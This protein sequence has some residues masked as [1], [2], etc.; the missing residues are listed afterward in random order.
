VFQLLKNRGVLFLSLSN[1]LAQLDSRLIHMVIITLVGAMFPG[2][3]SAF[4]GFAVAYSLPVIILAPFV[5]VLVDHWNRKSIMVRSHLI[6]TV[7]ICLTPF[8]IRLTHSFIP[9]WVMVVLFFSLEVFYNTAR[10]TS[11]PDLVAPADLIPANAIITAVARIATFLGMVAGAFLIKATGWN[12]GF[13]I[14][15]LVVLAA[16]LLILGMG[17][18]AVFEP[19]IKINFSLSHKLKKS[20]RVF[21]DDLKE[22]GRLLVHDRLVIFVMISVCVLPFVSAIAYTVLVYLIQQQ[23]RLGT[24]GVGIFG[25]VIGLGMLAGA[26]L[27]GFL[28]RK[29]SRGWIIIGSIAL[30]AALFLVGPLFV[31]P[32]FLYL[33]ALVS[34]LVYS[35]VGVAQDTM[36]QEDVA[37]DIRGRVF[38]TK[39]FFINLTFTLSAVLVGVLG[40]RVAPYT[41]VT[42]V[43]IIL[44][45]VTVFSAFVFNSI[46]PEIRAR[47]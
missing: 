17:S 44:V 15:G 21:G 28:D 29:I 31:S 32:F 1:F 18:Q 24:V 46:P 20:L 33:V 4:T 7:L 27:M 12:W 39:E 26:L 45:G 34:G 9:I 22:L 16:G 2:R 8:F 19:T 5:G 11:I 14:D 30:L 47:L 35:L 40:S 3:L 36:L 38:G 41:V 25:G 23:F 6:Q 43:G 42:W 13:Y 10:N 37:K